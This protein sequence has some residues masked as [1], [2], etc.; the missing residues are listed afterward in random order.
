MSDL[1]W[2]GGAPSGGLGNDD[3]ETFEV[4]PEETGVAGDEAAAL[5][6]RVGAD[7]EIGNCPRRSKNAAFGLQPLLVA[8]LHLAGADCGA[9]L[10]RQ[11]AD[12]RLLEDVEQ[13]G[14]EA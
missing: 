7:E 2:V 1:A 8:P 10:G 3:L 13:L 9:R 14:A 5:Q 12:P 11:E 6:Q 4:V